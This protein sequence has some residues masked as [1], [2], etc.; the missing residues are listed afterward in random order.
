M[1]LEIW[2]EPHIRSNVWGD[3]DYFLKDRV[4][5]LNGLLG[6]DEAGRRRG[7][8]E[9]RFEPVKIEHRGT[10]DVGILLQLKQNVF[11]HPCV[12]HP[13]AFVSGD[14]KK[15]WCQ[16]NRT[17]P[18]V[19]RQHIGDEPRLGRSLTND[20]HPGHYEVAPEAGIA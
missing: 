17:V 2:N 9:A 10:V 7:S 20:I 6:R 8:R 11:L 13:A 1:H 18:E 16:V 5:D 19:G 4:L 15:N 14:A 12:I 3:R